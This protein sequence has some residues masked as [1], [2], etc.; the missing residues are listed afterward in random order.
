MIDVLVQA[1]DESIAR[2]KK[3]GWRELSAQDGLI[4]VGAV[5]L[6]GA[7]AVVAIGLFFM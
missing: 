7:A 2:V 5:L 1:V 6:L 4:I 3:S